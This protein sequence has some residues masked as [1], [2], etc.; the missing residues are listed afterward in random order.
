M[1]SLRYVAGPQLNTALLQLGASFALALFL[2][3]CSQDVVALYIWLGVGRQLLQALCGIG[4]VW[5]HCL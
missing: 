2:F 3:S 4:M 1:F 5:S